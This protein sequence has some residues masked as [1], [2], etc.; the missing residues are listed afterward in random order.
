MKNDYLFCK[1]KCS[2]TVISIT[3]AS[4]SDNILITYDDGTYTTAPKT[5][6]SDSIQPEK[7]EAL[8]QS[9]EGLSK[10]LERLLDNVIEVGN[11]DGDTKFKALNSS[12][13]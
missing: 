1:K 7:I 9:V 10:N 8:T 2:K 6:I 3:P 13:E 11:I 12:F 4:D 5:V